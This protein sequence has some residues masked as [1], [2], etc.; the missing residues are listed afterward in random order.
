MRKNFSSKSINTSS[1]MKP[2]NAILQVSA[3]KALVLELM[4]ISIAVLM[5]ILAHALGIS[6]RFWL[7]MHWSVILA[8]LVL[9]W[10]GGAIVGLFSPL[11]NFMITG[12]PLPMILPSMTFELFAY[13]FVTGFLKEKV[14]LAPWLSVALAIVA[15]RLIFIASVLILG[16]V[17][18]AFVTSLQPALLP[19]LLTGVIQILV[20]PNV[21]KWW[22]NAFPPP[23]LKA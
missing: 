12:H 13:G 10:R 23:S 9:G 21:A 16:S 22:I 8:G 6:V 18:G 4:L 20:L 17:K 3:I 2:Q 7:P 5:P 11:V 1:M 15:G 19:G 14:N